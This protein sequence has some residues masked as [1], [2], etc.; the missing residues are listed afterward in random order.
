[1]DIELPDMRAHDGQLLLDLR[2]HA[3]FAK[4]TAAGRTAARQRDIDPFV[5]GRWR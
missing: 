3:R 2:R 1:V 4:A 5:D